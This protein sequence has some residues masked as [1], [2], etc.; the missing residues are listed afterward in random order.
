MFA[1]IPP[2]GPKTSWPRSDALT[3]EAEI[4]LVDGVGPMLALGQRKRATGCEE[5]IET[6]LTDVGILTRL[7]RPKRIRISAEAVHGAGDIVDQVI[8]QPDRL[9]E[10][11][12]GCL[13][14]HS[15]V[16][17]GRKFHGPDIGWK[18]LVCPDSQTVLTIPGVWVNLVCR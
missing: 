9:H 10:E 1:E 2:P 5:E 7:G 6:L 12:I 4:M 14:E 13:P 17:V 8:A 11:T 3:G 16:R 15:R 18:R